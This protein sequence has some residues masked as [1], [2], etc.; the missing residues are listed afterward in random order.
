MFSKENIREASRFIPPGKGLQDAH[1]RP[2]LFLSASGQGFVTAK[3]ARDEFERRVA[4]E[5]NRISVTNLGRDLDVD[6]E[7][8]LQL[9]EAFPTLSVFSI[10]NIHVIPQK[11]KNALEKDLQQLLE[12]Q[13]VSK[14]KFSIENDVS[15]HSV[16]TLASNIQSAGN[17]GSNA[18]HNDYIMS[19]T[20]RQALEDSVASRLH[21]SVHESKPADFSVSTLPGRPPMWLVSEIIQHALQANQLESQ[22]HMQKQEGSIHCIPRESIVRKRDEYIEQLRA[23]HLPCLE[24]KS[25]VEQFSQIFTSVE[26]AE[27]YVSTL[28]GVLLF[29]PTAV[30]EVWLA[31]FGDEC[32]GALDILGYADL[33]SKVETT[34]PKHCQG[35]VRNRLEAHIVAAYKERSGS[36]PHVIGSLLLTAVRYASEQ[37]VLMASAKAHAAHQWQQLKETPEKDL[38]FQMPEIVAFIPGNQPVLQA[39]SAEKGIEKVVED[40]YWGEIAAL[41]SQCELEFVTFWNDKVVSRTSNYEQGLSA[42]QDV[43]LKQQLSELLANFIAKDLLAD[44]VSKARSQALMS[45]RRTKKNVQ[46]LESTL[47]TGK[48][49]VALLASLDKFNKKQGIQEID[50]AFLASAKSTLVGDLTRKMKKQTDGP[51]LFLTLV[52]VLFAR[53]NPG[54]IYATGKFAPKLLKQLKSCLDAEQ[55]QQLERWKDSA[56]AGSLSAEDKDDMRRLAGETS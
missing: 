4:T 3:H 49:T 8:V 19:D 35:E 21:I 32:V 34:F 27:G 16:E 15:V 47:K 6:S 12:T 11:V 24:L 55:Y 41:E 10:D 1:S 29:R 51:V 53:H 56:K 13:V 25:L 2:L 30:S 37:D 17:A 5:S 54:L 36:E 26:D 20:Y 46:K 45:S 50:D 42:V 52:V 31:N 14:A 22:F 38:K 48:D 43:K 39:V 33:N 40:R 44:A 23:G 18:T 9:A 7:V 28:P